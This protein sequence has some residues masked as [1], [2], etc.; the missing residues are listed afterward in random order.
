MNVNGV[1]GD[2][3]PLLL[4]P[5]HIL[6]DNFGGNCPV[7]AEGWF[8]VGENKHR[9]Y[10]RARGMS[11]TCHVTKNSLNTAHPV[12]LE[13]DEVWKWGFAYGD[14]FHAGWI[15]PLLALGCLAEAYSLFSGDYPEH[16]HEVPNIN[17]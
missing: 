11:V 10:F 4:L 7:Q 2:I 5:R 8:Q 1:T 9:F 17:S 15:E 13:D 12:D 3:K 14:D 16:R 6:V